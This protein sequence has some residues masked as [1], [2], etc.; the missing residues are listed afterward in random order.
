[1]TGK[2]LVAGCSVVLL[3]AGCLAFLYATTPYQSA[4]QHP[5]LEPDQWPT[6]VEEAVHDFLS[7]AEPA[8][9]RHIRAT[10]K[11]DIILLYRD[12]GKTIRNRYGLWKS[13]EKL[14]I[15]ACGKLCVPDDASMNI[16]EAIWRETRKN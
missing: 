11:E 2:A 10:K 8:L 13:N 6:T 7:L 9:K 16:I 14:A 5:V 15:A 4:A 1:M 12:W 3:G